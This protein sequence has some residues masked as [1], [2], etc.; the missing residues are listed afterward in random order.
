MIK[1]A[2]MVFA[3]EKGVSE[4]NTVNDLFSELSKYIKE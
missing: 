3:F 1:T 2:E 4:S